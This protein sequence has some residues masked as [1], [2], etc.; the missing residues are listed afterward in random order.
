[1]FAHLKHTFAYRLNIAQVA[2]L[3]FPQPFV[4]TLPCQPVLQALEP[5]GEL[6]ETFHRIGHELIVIERL[7]KFNLKKEGVKQIN[8]LLVGVRHA[9]E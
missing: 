7:H 1:M 4:K 9:A 3:S 8:P 2:E 6:I 5:V